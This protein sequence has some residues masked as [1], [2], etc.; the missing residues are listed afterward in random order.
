[1]SLDVY[2]CGF[3]VQLP[4]RPGISALPETFTHV[5]VGTGENLTDGFQV[6]SL[7][8][9]SGSDLSL[10][11]YP[12][13]SRTRVTALVRLLFLSSLENYR[14]GNQV[15]GEGRVCTD[16]RARQDLGWMAGGGT[17]ESHFPSSFHCLM[18]KTGI[19]LML[20]VG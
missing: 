2:L 18:K 3:L 7:G 19:W 8:C 11:I 6:R 10:V 12:V 17:R 16:S 1:M 14:S 20:P 15:N 5:H 13:D 4:Q 9:E